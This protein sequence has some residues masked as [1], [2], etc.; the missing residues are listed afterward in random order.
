MKTATAQEATMTNDQI[1]ATL[2]QMLNLWDEAKERG[3][4]DDEIAEAF[5]ARFAPKLTK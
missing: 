4:D 2:R 5:T 1:K 3:M